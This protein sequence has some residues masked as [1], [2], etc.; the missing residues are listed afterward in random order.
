MNPKEMIPTV[1]PLGR[2]VATSNARAVVTDEDIHLGI[3]RHQ[4]GD[5]VYVAGDD[6]RANERA[7][8]HGERILSA[9]DAANG[10]RFW[11][12]T[13]GDRSLTVL[14]PEDY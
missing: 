14:L 11:I 3:W 5:W 7:L 8:I 9:Y 6:R 2:L 1:L 10:M 12:L 4:A 13:E